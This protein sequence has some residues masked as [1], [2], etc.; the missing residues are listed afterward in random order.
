METLPAL[1]PEPSEQAVVFRPRPFASDKIIFSVP[2]GTTIEGIVLACGL[3]QALRGCAKVWIDDYEVPRHLWRHARPNAGRTV[4]VAPVPQGG[5]GGKGT[6]ATILMIA[7]AVAA[8]AFAQ[9]LGLAIL[10]VEAGAASATQLAIASFIGGTLIMGAGALLSMALIPPP[11]TPNMAFDTGASLPAPNFSITGVSNRATPYG[12]IP[13][14]FGRRR[15]YPVLAARPYSETEG[16]KTYFRVL[17]LVGYGPIDISDLKIGETPIESFSGTEWEI[18][19]GGPDGWEGNRDHTLY[20]QSI[21]EDSFNLA[22]V[23]AG[24]TQGADDDWV[25]RISR[26]G[27]REISIDISF[28]GGLAG[29][30][31]D[32]AEKN[33]VGDRFPLTVELEV[34]YRKV[35]DVAW[36]TPT[37]VNASENGFGTPGEITITDMS[38]SLVRRGGL[39]RVAEAAQYE[40]QVRRTTTTSGPSKIDL[41]FWTALR[42]IAYETPITEPQVC[43]IAI[44][45][46]ATGQLNGVPDQINCIATSYLPVYTGSGWEWELSRN[47]AWAYTHLLRTRGAVSVIPDHRI[48][49][50]GMMAWADA[51]DAEPPNG[52][53]P[54]WTFDG[55]IEGGSLWNALKIVAAHGR[56]AYGTKDGKHCVVRDVEQETSIQP[57]TPRNSWAY[58]GTKLFVDLPHA[59]RVRFVNEELG[60]QEDELVVYDDG[61]TEENATRFETLDMLGSSRSAQSWRE[62]RYFIAVARLRPELHRVYMSAEQLRCTTGDLVRFAYDT[63][64]VGLGTGRVLSREVDDPE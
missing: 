24:E 37:W 45:M 42:S 20:T 4:Y 64:L 30:P 14:V 36:S 11:K 54:Y 29:F 16:N 15:V 39:F 58:E 23:R 35:G 32:L 50:E 22:L 26:I 41:T 31:A 8:A 63:I 43:T 19:E 53:A 6:F 9:P 1:R 60:Y 61:Y 7:V 10:G 28:P 34:R 40:V 47:P 18:N 62:G 21:R 12:P 33:A 56:A 55:V 13:R 44:R 17:L 25:S 48:D 3:P 27:T 51:C 57:I 52:P 49:L 2:N 38:Q 5:D 59:I 46:L